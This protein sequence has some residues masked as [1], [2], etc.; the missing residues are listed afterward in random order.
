MEL[1]DTVA[2][3]DRVPCVHTALIPHHHIG[4]T[5]QQIGDLSLPFIAPLRTDDNNVGQGHSGPKPLGSAM[6]EFLRSEAPSSKNRDI[7]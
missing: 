1:E 6:I 7:R 2:D 5:A 4:G 3:D